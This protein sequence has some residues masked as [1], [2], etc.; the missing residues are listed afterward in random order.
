M[1]Y[2][3]ENPAMDELG[4]PPFFGGTTGTTVGILNNPWRH[5]GYRWENHGSK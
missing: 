2:F 1:A 4:V 3:M 5:G